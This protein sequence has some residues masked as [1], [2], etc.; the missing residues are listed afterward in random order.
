MTFKDQATADLP[1]FV[2]VEEFGET[3]FTDG[4]SVACVLEGNDDTEGN[5]EGV[6]DR[7]TIIRAP[8]SSFYKVP[9]IGQR[10]SMDDDRQADV[11]AVS[12]DQGMVAMRVRWLDS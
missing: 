5:G 3:V 6:I 9:V 11:I 4:E 1:T 2:N 7:D 8:A 10:I 12:E